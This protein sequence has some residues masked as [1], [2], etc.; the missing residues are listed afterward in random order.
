MSENFGEL[1]QKLTSPLVLVIP[2]NGL[3]SCLIP[4]YPN[5]VRRSSDVDNVC[6]RLC[7]TAVEES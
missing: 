6:C 7:I 4:L 2:K 1:K 5:L 3:S